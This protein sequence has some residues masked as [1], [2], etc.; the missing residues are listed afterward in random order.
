MK[1]M[2]EVKK[3]KKNYGNFTAVDEIEFEVYR[4]EIF[5]FLGPNGAGKTTTQRMLTSLLTP[6]GGSIRTREVKSIV[7]MVPE[8]SNVYNELTAWDNLMF[9][10]QLYRIPRKERK[11]NAQELLELFGL[12]DKKDI[13]VENYS[14]GM[15]R[16]LSIAMGVIHQPQILFLDEPTPGLDPQSARTIREL[17]KDLNKNGSTIFLTTHQIEEA[18]QLCDRIAII[19]HGRIAAIDSPENLKT[20]IKGVQS[21][22]ISLEA[23]TTQKSS[24]EYDSDFSQLNG[25][26]NVI[27]IG[28]KWRLYTDDPT[29]LLSTLFKYAEKNQARIITLNT[30][31]PSLEEVYLDIIGD[32][33]SFQPK[34]RNPS[35]VC[36]RN[37]RHESILF[38]AGYD[39]VRLIDAVLYVFLLFRPQRDQRRRRN[40][41]PAGFDG[42]FHVRSCGSFCDPTRKAHRHI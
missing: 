10:G 30:L 2:I 9:T 23:T 40:S 1:N 12:W 39:H 26:R 25:V 20:R 6:T 27:K 22:K 41:K 14:K 36:D 5:G 13:K 42:V 21:V 17:I 11:K 8:E 19:D 35:S 38:A 24:K 29:N 3:L 32:L 7:G 28:D 31:T 33:Q 37:K 34:E 16:R 18:N 4:G 15:K